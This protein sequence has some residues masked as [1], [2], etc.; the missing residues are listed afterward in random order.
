[1]RCVCGRGGRAPAGSRRLAGLAVI[2]RR[3]KGRIRSESALERMDASKVMEGRD[4]RIKVFWRHAQ[5]AQRADP[6]G[7]VLSTETAELDVEALRTGALQLAVACMAV[8]GF[9][10][11]G[12]TAWS[13]LSAGCGGLVSVSILLLLRRGVYRASVTALARPA[14]TMTVLYLGA[15][16]RFIA[17]ILLFGI[18]LGVLGLEPKSMVAGFALTQISYIIRA[19]CNKGARR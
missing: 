7:V 17:V 4:R 6:T 14:R 2:L 13:A 18:G 1:M 12:A 19:S 10:W 11:F 5:G 9:L 16:Q 15:L 3:R 8:I